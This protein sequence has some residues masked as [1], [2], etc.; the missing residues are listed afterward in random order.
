MGLDQTS[1][2]LYNISQISAQVEASYILIPETGTYR[3]GDTNLIIVDLGQLAVNSEK[4]P[5][6][7]K[8]YRAKAAMEKARREQQTEDNQVHTTLVHLGYTP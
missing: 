3:P 6:A 5:Q 4:D 1:C 8:K 2:N 7:P